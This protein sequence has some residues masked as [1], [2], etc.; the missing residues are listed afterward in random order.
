MRRLRKD[1]WKSFFGKFGTASDINFRKTTPSKI[2]EN[3]TNS[4]TK[5]LLVH[6]DDERNQIFSESQI[7][8]Y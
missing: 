4:R 1:L 3:N 8:E 7:S 6:D 2:L 5:M